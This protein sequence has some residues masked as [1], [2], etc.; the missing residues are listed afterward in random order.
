MSNKSIAF[1]TGLLAIALASADAHAA[2]RSRKCGLGAA[3]H[4]GRRAAL[5]A[6]L[7]DGV[8]VVR[9][10]PPPREYVPFH[11][12]KTFWYLTGVESPDAAL[13][14]DVK[15]KKQILFLPDANPMA[16]LWNGERWDTGDAWVKELT[17]FE[18]VR[19][20][21]TLV[22]ALKEMTAS[23]KIAWISMEPY[24]GLG[25]SSDQAEQYNHDVEGDPLDGRLSREKALKAGL[26]KLLGV[27]VR[28]TQKALG[29]LRRVKMPEEV[30]ALRNASR[31]GAVAMTEAMRST[32]PGLGE[33]D[34]ESLMTF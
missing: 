20:I 13:V 32:R 30:E 14:M 19:S 18:D 15:T 11:Q 23:T 28:D 1:I 3:F 16:E 7:D 2:D 31:A 17:G 10:L 26:E 4:A 22:P 25:S 24:V 21:D 34:L 5:L 29:E 6:K 12:D 8:V 9:G 27:E 33:W